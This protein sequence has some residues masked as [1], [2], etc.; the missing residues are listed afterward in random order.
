MKG[1]TV[2][3]LSF[4]LLAGI[5]SESLGK[6]IGVGGFLGMNIPIAQED[7]STNSL[8]GIKARMNLIPR[9]GAEV[10][11]TK[12]NQGDSSVEVWGKDMSRDGGSINSFGLNLVVGSMSTD[13]GAHFHIAG[14]IGSYSLSKEGVPDQSR[15][16]YNFGPE[17]EIG[18]GSV[19]IEISS[20]AH[21]IPLEGGGSRKSVGLSG[22]L[23]YY[24]G[25]GDTY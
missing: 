1:T 13:V 2:V 8:F 10:F 18:L 20:K 19:S 12:L 24:F 23:N 5:A 17:V 25:L 15:W 14:G 22:G 3:F 4:L 16:G 9:L 7:A 11:F 6:K 21:I